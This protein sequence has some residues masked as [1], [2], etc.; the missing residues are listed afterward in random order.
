MRT[1]TKTLVYGAACVALMGLL[2]LINQI[3]GQVF[4]SFL[5]FFAPLPILVYCM[6]FD[7]RNG[8]L[9]LIAGILLGLLLGNIVAVFYL[10]GGYVAGYV[11]AFTKIKRYSVATQIGLTTL[12]SL[13]VNGL[14]MIGVTQLMDYDFVSEVKALTHQVME[15]YPLVGVTEDMIASVI[16]AAIV[17]SVLL[18]S[19]LSAACAYILGNIILKR[20]NLYVAPKLNNNGKPSKWVGYLLMVGLFAHIFST[21]F[22]D[23][24]S[25]YAFCNVI[26]LIATFILA[27]YGMKGF[28]VYALR[29][30]RLFIYTL[31]ILGIFMIPNVI[32]I[33]LALAGFLYISSDFFE[34][35]LK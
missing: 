33:L 27:V 3:S 2:Y 9:V 35:V 19:L 4:E 18:D 14:V 5:V 23:N 7:L 22:M 26:G 16:P 29:T 21:Q 31:L 25:L 13:L 6:M 32:L 24:L 15:V 11:L 30:R 12:V 8:A 10:M 34:K 28:R 17:L 20:L 1:N